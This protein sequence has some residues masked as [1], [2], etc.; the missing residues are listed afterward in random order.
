MS[1]VAHPLALTGAILCIGVTA[2]HEILVVQAEPASIAAAAGSALPVGRSR[3]TCHLEQAVEQ[4]PAALGEPANLFRRRFHR[5]PGVRRG[6]PL[7]HARIFAQ[8]ANASADASA[9]ALDQAQRVSLADFARDAIDLRGLDDEAKRIADAIG[10]DRSALAPTKSRLAETSASPVDVDCARAPLGC[11]EAQYGLAPDA[12]SENV[13]RNP[14]EAIDPRRPMRF[15]NSASPCWTAACSAS[16]WE[17]RIRRFASCRVRSQSRGRAGTAPR[18]AR[19]A[20]RLHPLRRDRP[21]AAEEKL[22]S[23]Y[24]MVEE[25]VPDLDD[26]FRARIAD[27]E[28]GRERAKASLDRELSA[29]CRPIEIGPATAQSF[30]RTM[31]ENVTTGETP[32]R[33]SW[34]RSVVERIEVDDEVTR[35]ISGKA[36]CRAGN[37]SQMCPELALPRGLEPLFSP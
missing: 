1:R 11:V 9:D 10:I 18:D 8:S 5:R 15:H 27:L 4:P 32:F 31:R 7:G 20:A 22:A 16:C 26:V 2:P 28:L 30:G 36:T 25:G 23:L 34:L 33:K 3:G 19:A 13:D 24:K 14:C 29:Q 35:I 12:Q 21:E 6:R 37:S 17:R